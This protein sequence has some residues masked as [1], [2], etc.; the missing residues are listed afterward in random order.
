MLRVVKSWLVVLFLMCVL[1]ENSLASEYL[2]EWGPSNLLSSGANGGGEFIAGEEIDLRTGKLTYNQVDVVVPGNGGMDIVVSRSYQKVPLPNL[3]VPHSIGNWSLDVPRIIGNATNTPE[4]TDSFCSDPRPGDVTLSYWQP[5]DYILESSGTILGWDNGDFCEKN[6]EYKYDTCPSMLEVKPEPPVQGSQYLSGCESIT[7]VYVDDNGEE[8]E[9]NYERCTLHTYVIK[10]NGTKTETVGKEESNPSKSGKRTWSGL[11]LYIPNH[12]VRNLLFSNISSLDDLDNSTN[13]EYVTTDNWK[14]RC[15]DITKADGSIRAGAGFEVFSPAG[16]KYTFAEDARA[17]TSKREEDVLKKW[18]EVVEPSVEDQAA[19]N[20]VT[21]TYYYEQKISILAPSDDKPL[22]TNWYPQQ[23]LATKV[24]DINGNI[25]SY[26]YIKDGNGMKHPEYIRGTDASGN[27]QS[28]VQ[29]TYTDAGNVWQ[30]KAGVKLLDKIIANNREWIFNYDDKKQLDYVIRPD[31]NVFIIKWDYEYLG[32]PQKGNA[33]G[34]RLTKISHPNSGYIEYIYQQKEP[35]FFGDPDGKTLWL[36]DTRKTSHSLDHYWKYTP[37]SSAERYFLDRNTYE[38]DGASVT[39]SG[40]EVSFLKMNS[41]DISSPIV[42]D[43][44]FYSFSTNNDEFKNKLLYESKDSAKYLYWLKEK[45][46]DNFVANF[47]HTD[48]V[49]VDEVIESLFAGI[50]FRRVDYSYASDDYGLPSSINWSY[51]KT[52]GTISSNRINYTYRHFTEINNKWIIGLPKT[53]SSSGLSGNNTITWNYYEVNEGD[54]KKGNLKSLDQFGITESY[55]YFPTGDLNTVTRNLDASTEVT[56]TYSDYKRGV[57]RDIKDFANETMRREVNDDG[58]IKSITDARNNKTSYEYDSLGRTTLIDYPLGDDF[59]ATWFRNGKQEWW[60]ANGGVSSLKTKTTFNGFSQVST[61][62]QIDSNGLTVA[63]LV[64]NEYDGKG[65]LKLTRSPVNNNDTSYSWAEKSYLYNELDRVTKIT[66]RHYNSNQGSVTY[67][68]EDFEYNFNPNLGYNVVLYTNREDRVTEHYFEGHKPL[69]EALYV[70]SKYPENIETEVTRDEQ[71]KV[72]YVS[73]GPVNDTSQWLVREFKY[74]ANQLLEYLTVPELKN[75]QVDAEK[76]KFTYDLRGNVKT[77]TVGTNEA[78]TYYYDK[79]SRLTDIDFPGTTPNVRYAYDAVGNLTDNI[80]HTE[81][82]SAETLQNAITNPMT[83]WTTTYDNNN[84]KTKQT[85]SVDEHQFPFVYNYN[86][87]QQHEKTIYPSGKVIDYA[88]D[89]WGVKTKMAPFITD[90]KF[91]GRGQLSSKTYANNLVD[92][93]NH[94]VNAKISYKAA[95]SDLTTNFSKEQNVDSVISVDYGIWR[96]DYDKVNR[97]THVHKGDPIDPTKT[98]D[99]FANITYDELGN[100]KT[101]DKMPTTRS[102]T[103]NYN[104]SKQL[105]SITDSL[106]QYGTIK[107]DSYGN[108]T[109]NGIKSFTYDDA[110]HLTSIVGT[111]V[112]YEYDGNDRLVKI[113]NGDKTTYVVYGQNS[114]RLLEYKGAAGDSLKEFYYLNGDLIASRELTDLADMDT[115]GD[116]I[117]DAYELQYGLEVGVAYVAG[118]DRDGDKVND[119]IEFQ[120]GTNAAN[121]DSDSDGVNDY[122]EIYVH[123]T[124]PLNVDSDGD[125]ET[126]GEEVLAGRNPAVNE[127]VLMTIINSL[128]LN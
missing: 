114:K 4:G 98:P 57:A 67:Y 78:I 55:T 43:S 81:T 75:N 69:E 80:T 73:Q 125:G 122:D 87:R 123:F 36:L 94:Y 9:E 101:F 14:A 62:K 32:A 63:T 45:I 48:R 59:V 13:V 65:R 31:T 79:M 84:N 17:N 26:S 91:I 70:G 19:G 83:H 68:D 106:N 120:Q 35:T 113:I 76:I 104:S 44:A 115:D 118:D 77:K 86:S 33:G 111:G 61:V 29:F 93:R 102:Q 5:Y 52:T 47:Y 11:Q 41:A 109:S 25:I 105:A 50:D 119:L 66:H 90:L 100:I 27:A 95:N 99:E 23:W 51:F 30:S 28:Q 34:A 110:N 121:S 18:T 49:L 38:F 107:Y 85:L 60:A 20:T 6:T 112:Q 46:G 97:L 72:Q 21:K 37:S 126:D 117:S 22:P 1:S 124:N 54:N 128:L 71:G 74:N 108:I 64:D 40:M 10:F 8:T 42:I 39:T 16:L 127:A 2:N 12:G 15:I 7:D 56:E 92:T 89:Y 3:E 88:P 82:V 96:F 116:S 103:Y 58:T 53:K 24:E